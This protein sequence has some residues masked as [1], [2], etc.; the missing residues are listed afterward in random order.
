MLRLGRATSAV[1]LKSV[2]R[3][4]CQ[5]PTYSIVVTGHSL[6]AGVAAV[7]GMLWVHEFKQLQCYLYGCPA[8][9]SITLAQSC[10]PFMHSLICGN[11]VIPRLSISAVDGLW[12]QILY[13][14]DAPQ[15]ICLIP[16]AFVL[17][18]IDSRVQ[19]WWSKFA[20]EL[21]GVRCR[22]RHYRHRPPGW[23]YWVD[24]NLRTEIVYCSGKQLDVIPLS[25]GMLNDHLPENYTR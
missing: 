14:N 10:K 24:P 17:R 2:Q 1:L 3:L 19:D 9:T 4:V 5:Q 25:A 8:L 7:L 16:C 12:A 15:L 11:D 23:Q 20:L 22:G 13:L 18:H 21:E 6:G